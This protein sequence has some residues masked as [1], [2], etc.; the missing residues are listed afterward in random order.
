MKLLCCI[1]V[2][3]FF[4]IA[5]AQDAGQAAKPTEH[6]IG[7]VAAVDQANHTVTLKDDAGATH[8][9][10]LVDTKTLLKVLPNAKDLKGATRITSDDL[11]PGDRVDVRGFKVESD[12]TG[13]AARSVLLMS[14]RDLQ[15]VHQAEARAWQRSTA[16]V[17]TAIDA[18]GQKLTVATHGSSP[19]QSVVVDASN[20]KFTRYS[21]ET[22]KTPTASKFTDIQPGDQVKIIGDRTEGGST[23][24]AQQIYS[25]SFKSLAGT[26]VSL[27]PDGKSFVVKD[28][29]TKQPVSVIL[30][31][32]SAVR[33]LPPMMANGLA[34]R[35]NPDFKPAPTP[36]GAAGPGGAGGSASGG[37]S[38]GNAPVAR[39]WPRPPAGDSSGP[40]D[41]GGG[42]RPGGQGGFQGGP[43]GMRPG[44]NGDLSQML[45]RVPKIAISDL[46]PGDAVIVAGSPASASKSSLLAVNVIA[47]VEP[48]FQSASPRQAQSLGGDWGN[49]L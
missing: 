30:A 38:G 46:K 40:P 43:A 47:G 7:T 24:T 21:P 27:A 42:P 39:N 29:Q 26:L 23:M 1:T 6:L 45:E 32:D 28:L 16:G 9:V 14:G 13:I 48:I 2:L 33:R 8:V 35:F 44:G 12:P 11:A 4:N 31:D 34:R 17:V 25:G 20:T 3:S 19:S 10:G 49:A 15:Q 41:G 5:A 37:D 36:D 18:P 22:P